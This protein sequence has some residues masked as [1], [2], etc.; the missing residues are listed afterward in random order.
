MIVPGGSAHTTRMVGQVE[1]RTLYMR[2]EAVAWRDPVAH[3]VIALSPLLRLLVSDLGAIDNDPAQRARA[4]HLSQLILMDLGTATIAALA[5]PT[6]TH[7]GLSRVCRALWDDPGTSRQ[8]DHWADE[9]GMS[10]RS[11][12][13]ALVAQTGLTFR[14]WV[15]RSRCLLVLADLERG[16]SLA[17]VSARLGYASP[18]ALR[19]MIERVLRIQAP[20]APRVPARRSRPRR[21]APRAGG[22]A[23]RRGFRLLRSS[24][25]GRSCPSVRARPSS[26]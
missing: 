17:D 23:R 24:G 13:R 22:P 8:I 18:Y 4:H 25:A 20:R 7:P 6:P 1:V 5:L 12:T 10:R 2:A 9:I 3:R 11:F 21:G 15:Q 26:G 19:A 14:A 16:E